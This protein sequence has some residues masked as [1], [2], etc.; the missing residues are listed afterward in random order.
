MI[1]DTNFT[2]T[3]LE[4]IPFDTLYVRCNFARPMPD[5]AS[6]PSPQG[7]KL[8]P[9]ASQ[10][11]EFRACN[12]TNVEPPIGAIVDEFTNTQVVELDISGGTE[13]GVEIN[14]VRVA[15]HNREKHRS[16]GKWK[17]GSYEYHP[18]PIEVEGK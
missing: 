10:A 14:G 4:E 18:T 15:T 16:H 1:S 2:N 5:M 3:P 11:V 6:G 17:G 9:L 12:L 8:F 7:H 13:D